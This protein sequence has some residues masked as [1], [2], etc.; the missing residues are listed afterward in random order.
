MAQKHKLKINEGVT[1][2]DQA[3]SDLSQP[4]FTYVVTA[5]DGLFKNGKQYKKGQTIELTEATAKNFVDLGEVEE[6]K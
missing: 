1:S 6:Q 3:G 2:S 4:R 5:E